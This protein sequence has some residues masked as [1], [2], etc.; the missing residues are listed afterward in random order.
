M[1]EKATNLYIPD[2]QAW[3]TFYGNKAKRDQKV[4]FGFQTESKAL[5]QQTD[6]VVAGTAERVKDC[7]QSQAEPKIVNIVS[8]TEQTVQAAANVMKKAGIKLKK[9]KSRSSKQRSKRQNTSKKAKCRK[10]AARAGRKATFSYRTLGDI[11]SKR[12]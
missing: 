7:E 8:P 1:T 10:R 9:V 5:R 3:E 2:Y 12:K 4:G 11:F 6:V